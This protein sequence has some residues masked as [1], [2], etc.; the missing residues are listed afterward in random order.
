MSGTNDVRR[1]A[2]REGVLKSAKLMIGDSVMDCL[3]LDLSAKGARVRLNAPMALPG[4]VTLSFR[5]GT[6]Y[7]AEPRWARSQEVGL[8]FVGEAAVTSKTAG[9]AASV[10]QAMREAGVGQVFAA[11]RAARDF[12]D[13]Q[14]AATVSAAREAWARLEA[15]LEARAHPDTPRGPDVFAG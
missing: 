15:A 9:E 14:L 1:G 6:S 13:P 8:A 2:V 4:R 7:L 10:L 11:L 12:D 5:G 3:V